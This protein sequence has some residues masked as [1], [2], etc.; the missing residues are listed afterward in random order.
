MATVAHVAVGL[1]A[2]RL[3]ARSAGVPP[4]RAMLAFSVLSL[5]PDLDVLGNRLGIK[6]ADPWGHRGATHAL[7]FALV[8]GLVL[9]AVAAKSGHPFRRAALFAVPVLASHGV[10]DAFTDGGH[11][12][13]LWWPFSDARVFWP[14]QP[15]PVAP[16]GRRMLS[17]RGAYVLGV[18]TLICA[19]LLLYALWPRRRRAARP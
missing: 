7:F 1:V 14:W 10:L 18:E 2:G 9:A 6:Y 4:W 13:A 16:I 3:Y 17:A 11:G 5:A 12:A 19:P 8:A 15:L